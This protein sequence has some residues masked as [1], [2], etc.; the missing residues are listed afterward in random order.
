MYEDN[1]ITEL[2]SCL[3]KTFE[4]ALRRFNE[5]QLVEIKN[6]TSSDGSSISFISCP[7]K[8]LE[9]LEDIKNMINELQQF[10]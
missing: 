9:K 5:I 7:F 4:T 10:D 2:S 6:Y 3:K 8:M 1:L